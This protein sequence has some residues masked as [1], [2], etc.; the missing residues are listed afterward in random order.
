MA[1]FSGCEHD[2]LLEALNI[3]EAQLRLWLNS[4]PANSLLF[5]DDPVG[6]LRAADIGIS[7]KL[8]AELQQIVTALRRKL[9]TTEE[10]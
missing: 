7:E 3:H 9:R 1:E 5:R 8:L 4:S 6:A 2:G 10:C